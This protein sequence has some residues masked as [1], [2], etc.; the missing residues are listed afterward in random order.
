MDERWYLKKRGQRCCDASSREV[1]KADSYS[2]EAIQT[3][4]ELLVASQ[5][6]YAESS[7]KS[8]SWKL[9]IRWVKRRRQSYKGSKT[10]MANEKVI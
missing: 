2:N 4:D 3:I 10:I 5:E 9:K 7:R 1:T 6:R 8:R